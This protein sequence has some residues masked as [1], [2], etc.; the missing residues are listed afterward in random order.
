VALATI[1]GTL[2]LIIGFAVFVLPFYG[3]FEPLIG[4]TIGLALLGVLVGATRHG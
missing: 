1:L 4:G 2:F 3:V